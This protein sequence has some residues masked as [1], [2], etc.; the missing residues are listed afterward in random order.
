M[1][2]SGNHPGIW[3]SPERQPSHRRRRRCRWS[4]SRTA[5]QLYHTKRGVPTSRPCRGC[6]EAICSALQFTAPPC[7]VSSMSRFAR[8]D[9]G[10][11]SRSGIGQAYRRTAWRVCLDRPG[12][13]LRGCGKDGFRVSTIV[14]AP[15]GRETDRSRGHRQR[16]VVCR[17]SIG[18]TAHTVQ[19]TPLSSGCPAA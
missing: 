9:R 14:S 19:V 17:D 3:R 16:G 12:V 18:L 4:Q 5:R 1:H 11:R 7:P 8:Q 2:G 10:Y 6:Q 15:A 13:L